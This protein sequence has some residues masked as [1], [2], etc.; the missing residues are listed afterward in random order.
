MVNGY[1][2]RKLIESGVSLKEISE[3]ENKRNTYISRIIAIGYLSPKII[4]CIF[5]ADHNE[6]LTIGALE[7][8]ANQSMDWKT[9]EE[10]F[11]QYR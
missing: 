7:K 1:K 5:K 3:K 8:I 2:Y 6:K 9:Q 11:C 4:E 10:I